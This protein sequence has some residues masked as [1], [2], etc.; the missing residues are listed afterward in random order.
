MIDAGEWMDVACDSDN[1]RR[2]TGRVMG[3]EIDTKREISLLA[4]EVSG[5]QEGSAPWS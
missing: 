3:L 4:E 5:S 2:F 1:W